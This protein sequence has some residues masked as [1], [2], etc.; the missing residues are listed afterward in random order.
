MF[1]SRRSLSYANV[2]A[3]VALV[4]SMSGGALAATHYL[5]NSTSQINPK[6][7]K[8][9]KANAGTNGAPGATGSGGAA[10]PAGPAGPVG[11]KGETGGTGQRGEKGAG[12]KGE[13]GLTG[14][15]GEKGVTGDAGTAVAYAHVE[16]NKLVA[17]VAPSESKGIT[18]ADVVDPEEE[19]GLV[20]ISGLTGTLHNVVVSLESGSFASTA[21]ASLVP[22]GA[23]TRCPK[24]TQIL[25]ETLLEGEEWESGFYIEVN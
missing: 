8:A 25:V 19:E 17:T 13:K 21:Q 24:G 6:V 7:L 14:E 18:S 4:L 9:L 16:L 1:N 2:T 15:K 22:A 12:E 10:G 5:I 11:P 20:C 23:E 3:T